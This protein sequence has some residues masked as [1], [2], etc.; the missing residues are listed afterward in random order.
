MPKKHVTRLEVKKLMQTHC[1]NTHQTHHTSAQSLDLM[2]NKQRKGLQDAILNI[3]MLAKERG[4][5]DMTT[6]EISRKHEENMGNGARCEPSSLTQPV[7][8]LLAAGLIE[9]VPEQ[10]KCLISTHPAAPLRLVL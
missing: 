3:L 2:G 6:K 1:Q 5:S 7:S 8:L 4:V 9:R 10:R